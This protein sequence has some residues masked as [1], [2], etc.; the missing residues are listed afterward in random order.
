M[1]VL[2]LIPET[3]PR[4]RATNLPV[5]S[6]GIELKVTVEKLH[7][8]MVKSHGVGISACQAGINKQIMIIGTKLNLDSPSATVMINPRI[9][10]VWGSQI[11]REGCLSLPGKIVNVGRPLG[12]MISFQDMTG[13]RKEL[14][15]EG[16]PATVCCHEADHTLQSKLIIDY[17]SDNS[18]E[19]SIKS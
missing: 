14:K 19:T 1:S 5:T 12:I 16:F 11:S 9:T 3:D 7:K 13:K 8:L 6:F 4:L 10:K 17:L 15:V 2:K 18:A